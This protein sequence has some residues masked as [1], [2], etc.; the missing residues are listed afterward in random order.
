MESPIT[1]PYHKL[2]TVL[3][4]MRPSIL[5][6][7]LQLKRIRD[8]RADGSTPT[9]DSEPVHVAWKE[10]H[11]HLRATC[12][13]RTRELLSIVV[14]PLPMPEQER[15]LPALELQLSAVEDP[16]QGVLGL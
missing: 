12:D 15:Q 7:A 9:E 11:L 4:R 3:D 8:Y 16:A 14:Q 13:L 1:D 5:S 6:Y 2:L 10:G